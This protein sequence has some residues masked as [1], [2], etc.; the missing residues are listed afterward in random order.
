MG[1]ILILLFALG[2][3]VGAS[4]HAQVGEPIESL[5]IQDGGRIK[6]FDTFA[7]ESLQLV[8]GKQTYEGKS[9]TE[10]VFTWLLVPD[11]WIETAFIELRHTGLKEAL[12]ITS[13]ERW[14]S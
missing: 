8:Y 3:G 11:H 5:P 7:R 6:P 10:V 4:S 2:L 9:A 1:R 12:K 13:S 14:Y